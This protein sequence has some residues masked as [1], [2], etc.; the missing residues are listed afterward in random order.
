MSYTV[1]CPAEILRTSPPT[2]LKMTIVLCYGPRVRPELFP[3]EV[4]PR[5]THLA[6]VLLY[7]K[8]AVEVTKGEDIS[9]LQWKDLLVRAHPLCS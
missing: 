3:P 5:L 7:T 4:V 9:T 1:E 6:L 8:P 2:H